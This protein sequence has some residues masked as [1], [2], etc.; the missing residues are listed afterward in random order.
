VL[1]DEFGGD[2]LLQVW[3]REGEKKYEK[4]LNSKVMMWSQSNRYIIYKPGP[5]E[6]D[7]E[8]FIIVDTQ[9]DYRTIKLR[10]W[11]ADPSYCHSV[12]GA[13]SFMVANRNNI[14][15]VKLENPL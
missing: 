5:E 13:S 8:F 15:V 11:T 2:Y 14:Q 9:S 7:S 10:D 6:A 12:Y 4:V 3:N 1:Q